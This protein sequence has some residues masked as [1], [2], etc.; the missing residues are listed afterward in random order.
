MKALKSI[1]TTILLG[2]NALLS[3]QKS[4]AAEM[5]R[6]YVQTTLTS[7]LVSP[8][9]LTVAENARQDWISINPIKKMVILL[10]NH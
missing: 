8:A 5:P 7:A 6:P 1:L 3:V 10:G 2:A 9:G 4:I